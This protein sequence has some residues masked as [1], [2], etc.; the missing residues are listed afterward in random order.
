MAQ[1]AA[2]PRMRRRNGLIGPQCGHFAVGNLARA[3]RR[4]VAPWLHVVAGRRGSVLFSDPSRAATGYAAEAGSASWFGDGIPGRLAAAAAI[5]RR[6][7]SADA[8][9]GISPA[10]ARPAPTAAGAR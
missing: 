10:S 8:A 1:G 6:R 4:N 7:T 3:A 9:S 2:D 5:A